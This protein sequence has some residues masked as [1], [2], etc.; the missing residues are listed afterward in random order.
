MG[1]R[2]GCLLDLKLALSRELGG[3]S[4]A[5]NSEQLFAGGYAACCENA[6]H[7]SRYAGH[8]F[9]DDDIDVG[10]IELGR[11]ETGGLV[12][13]ARQRPPFVPDRAMLRLT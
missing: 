1:Q 12:L 11:N 2:R 5:T 4:D 10:K 13:A 8:R 7:V 6:L 3:R 9:A